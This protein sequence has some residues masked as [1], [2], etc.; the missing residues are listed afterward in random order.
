M[1][2]YI[3]P[4]ANPEFAIPPR[5]VVPVTTRQRRPPSDESAFRTPPRRADH[6]PVNN[7][8][9]SAPIPGPS[10]F[11]ASQHRRASAVPTTSVPPV[12]PRASPSYYR[13]QL[14]HLP[15]EFS[16]LTII[17]TG[18]APSQGSLCQSPATAP[19]QSSSQ[20]VDVDPLIHE[21]ALAYSK[22]Q[23]QAAIHHWS[24]ALEIA[25][26]NQDYYNKAKILSNLSNAFRA[27]GQIV[28]SKA[29]IGDALNTAVT[30]IRLLQ[31]H[32]SF[33]VWMNQVV[34]YVLPCLA[35]P[36]SS[37]GQFG[38]DS[39]SSMPKLPAQ[40]GPWLIVW[41]LE[42]MSTNGNALFAIR[43][44]FRAIQVHSQCY[45]IARS[46][47][48]E[49][50]LPGGVVLP[51]PGSTGSRREKHGKTIRFSYLHRSLISAQSRALTHLGICNQ[52]LGLDQ[53]AANYHDQALAL[54]DFYTSQIGPVEHFGRRKSE[55]QQDTSYMEE[56]RAHIL[57]NKANAKF[58]L[59]D[60]ASAT[61]NH[62]MSLKEFRRLKRPRYEAIE[63]ANLATISVHVGYRVNLIHWIK[64]I[65][66]AIAED[67]DLRSFEKFWGPCRI[68]E[69]NVHKMAHELPTD[70]SGP[71]SAGSGFISNGINMT[72]DSID[73]LKSCQDWMS[74]CMIW[75]NIASAFNA[76][77]Q[78]YYALYYLER[79]IQSMDREWHNVN[80]ARQ[81]DLIDESLKL[82]ATDFPEIIRPQVESAL[83]Q[84]LFHLA[85]ISSTDQTVDLF[86]AS[87]YSELSGLPIYDAEPINELLAALRI[88]A[89]ADMFQDQG[90]LIS[91]LSKHAEDLYLYI[92]EH[93]K[94]S[95]SIRQ[96]LPLPAN[97]AY[98]D[99][100]RKSNIVCSNTIGKIYWE[101][102]IQ[103]AGNMLNGSDTKLLE[104][105]LQ[106]GLNAFTHG[107]REVDAIVSARRSNN[108]LRIGDKAF[109]LVINNTAE[110]LYGVLGAFGAS[111]LALIVDLS[112]YTQHAQ[113]F[114]IDMTEAFGYPGTP[115]HLFEQQLLECAQKMCFMDLGVCANCVNR[116]CNLANHHSYEARMLRLESNPEEEFENLGVDTLDLLQDASRLN[117]DCGKDDARRQ[118]SSSS[119]SMR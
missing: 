50:P 37:N 90:T 82:I 71:M 59:G 89:K 14:N 116:L 33:N 94:A 32:D 16:N 74:L 81:E 53:I 17:Q 4:T 87:H 99:V 118:V 70:Q 91:L 69:V 106:S 102:I 20:Q 114:H 109:Q 42:L 112:R 54:V 110:H 9:H 115:H 101:L 51:S 49:Y 80:Q 5:R 39:P 6:H 79:V 117:C 57:A 104:D 107:V 28:K 22:F 47:F 15:T 12:P 97:R 13:I 95:S 67:A 2:P 63:Q 78:P 29:Y 35:E 92:S 25:S 119:S 38:W 58:A 24:L 86:P 73:M 21:G 62:Q 23:Y 55:S 77:G 34:H 3:D 72:Y 66:K 45:N 46:I 61:E 108:Y 41:F 1:N 113:Q 88:D 26:R 56:Y 76:Q 8:S 27:L 85:R 31:H 10:S 7:H 100:F 84:A 98:M 52:F 36:E 60:V 83:T 64:S 103:F 111:M 48:E 75:V 40:P 43:Q 11:G 68:A 93:A 44:V 105:F 18:A 96:V 30:L 19:L 65:E